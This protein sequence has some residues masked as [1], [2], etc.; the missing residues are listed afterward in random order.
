MFGFPSTFDFSNV[1]EEDVLFYLGNSIVVDVLKAFVP[2]IKKYFK[3][4]E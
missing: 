2:Q 3:T 4:I 1:S